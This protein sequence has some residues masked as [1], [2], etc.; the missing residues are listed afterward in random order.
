MTAIHQLRRMFDRF[1]V[2]P[3]PLQEWAY[4][5]SKRHKNLIIVA[6]TGSGKT[7][8]AYLASKNWGRTTYA[9]PMKTLAN[10]IHDRLNTYERNVTGS[11]WSVQ[12][13]SNQ[14]DRHLAND[15]SVS[16]IDQVLSGYFGFGRE[17]FMRGKNV[18]RNH[19]IL[20]EVQLFDPERALQSLLSLLE[21]TTAEP[22]NNHFCMMTATFPTALHKYLETHFN[23][24]V[25]IE[26][27]PPIHKEV[28]LNWA[29]TLPVA[30]I[31]SEQ[32]KQIIACNT[33]QQQVDIYER[34][35]KEGV[36]P[37]RLVVLN[38]RLYPDDRERAE[39]L[40]HQ[41]FGKD[42]EEND[43]ILIATQII[44]AGMDISADTFYTYEAP[45][46]SLI[47][48]EGRC[49]RWGGK[50]TFTVTKQETINGNHPVYSNELITDTSDIIKAHI[51]EYFT[52]EKQLEWTDAVLNPLYDNILN[53]RRKKKMFA[54]ELE[55]GSSNA[56]IRQI[57]SIN[58]IPLSDPHTATDMDFGR[59]SVSLSL[60]NVQKHEVMR[61]DT[62]PKAPLVSGDTVIVD[63]K[64]WTYDACG[65]RRGGGTVSSEFPPDYSG[66]ADPYE[67]YIDESLHEHLTETALQLEGILAEEGV[68]PLVTPTYDAWTIGAGHDVGKATTA[69]QNWIRWNG[70]GTWAD[71][72]FLYAHRP[73]VARGN[74]SIRGL[75]HSL[76]GVVLLNDQL[77]L[78]E[79][80]VIM[81]HHGRVFPE[82][83]SR[84]NGTE[85]AEPTSDLL[86][87]I[88]FSPEPLTTKSY[89]VSRHD[90][91]TPTDEEWPQLVYLTGAL[92]QA[93]RQAIHAVKARVMSTF[94]SSID[95]TTTI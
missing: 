48:R 94:H 12:H 63:A 85:W 64:A 55:N 25:Y 4:T 45:I 11:E 22:F 3:R 1:D 40:V 87:T 75:T 62:D 38:S 39:T 60:H 61:H 67:D 92:M 42:S 76:I 26:R 47:Q 77:T 51:S 81:S 17:A 18:L 31:A 15:L 56:L 80:N 59:N 14:T 54:R 44:E 36:N 8:A 16:T 30:T 33:Q 35:I 72:D 57:Q 13:S 70:D 34:L 24:E 93:D 5:E 58:V 53:N 68:L 7:E 79:K 9:L 84:V 95:K 71:D 21:H 83:D 19:L 91:L 50:G 73:W 90:I 37:K 52:W 69:W 23:A 82:Q 89:R 49:S 78:L 2:T 6:P 32:T 41:H 88:G 66:D 65:L 20:D 74:A 29:D 86:A 46:D 43:K 28:T 27:T 10:D